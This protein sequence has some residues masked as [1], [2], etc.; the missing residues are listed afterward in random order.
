MMFSRDNFSSSHENA[1]K[2]KA[3]EQT[4]EKLGVLGWI[5]VNQSSFPGACILVSR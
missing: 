3:A 1:D 2:Y 4:D 5:K